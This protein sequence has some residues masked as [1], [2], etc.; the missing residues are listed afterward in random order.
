MG[1]FTKKGYENFGAAMEKRRSIYDIKNSVSLTDAKI[2]SI[3]SDIIKHV[4][5]AFNSQSTRMVLLLND[6]HH[7][8]WT[9][10]ADELKKLMGSERD[11]TATAQKIDS[12]KAGYGTVL[13][14][15]D[16]SIIKGLQQQMPAY[17]DNFPIW[18]HHASAMHQYAVWTAFA[19]ENIGASLQHYNG[20]VDEAV[21]TS[22]D[23]PREWKL[24]AQM[25]FGAIG[26]PAGPKE[27]EPVNKR[28]IVKK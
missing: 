11:F 10:T 18:S 7:K 21:Y 13:F 27:F 20:V 26:T 12:F 22:F 9:L 23:I 19:T 24:I 4:P 5:S 25:P 3:L 15:E 28:L 16:E 8:F 17:S 14:F 6:Q 2:E 1:L